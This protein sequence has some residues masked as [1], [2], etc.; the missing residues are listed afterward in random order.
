MLLEQTLQVGQAET[1]FGKKKP[2]NGQLEAA[3]NWYADRYQ[4]VV[5]QRNI[6]ALIT[7]LALAGLGVT[8]FAVA[9]IAG[10]KTF[11]PFVLEIESKTGITTVVDQNTF[12]KFK[13]DEAVI[14]YFVLKYIN[15]REGYDVYNYSFDYGHVVRLLS[16]GQVYGE[17][18]K[19]VGLDNPKSPIHLGNK[20]RRVS[21]KSMTFL[22]A[23]KVQ[24]RV[25][26]NDSREGELHR[27]ITV[28]FEFFDLNLSLAERYINPLGF[29]VVNYR[30]DEEAV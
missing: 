17:F 28:D 13:A 18:V 3:K 25:L 9:R 10:S 27:V 19:S 26:I 21:L 20:T 2:K 24:A 16:S 23:K 14:R 22:T 6:L 12:S 5:V 15:A 8:T 4:F 7:L 11:E 30:N 29:Q 1:M